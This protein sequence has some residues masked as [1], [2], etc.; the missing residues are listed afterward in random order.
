MAQV[1]ERPPDPVVEPPRAAIEPVVAA[2]SNYDWLP[3]ALI[4]AIALALRLFDLGSR[5]MHHDESL[6]AMYSWYLYTGRGYSHDPLMHG[7]F[8]FHLT[9]LIFMLFGDSEVTFRLPHVLMGTAAVFLPYFLR[10]ELGRSGAIAA[11]A[12]LAFGPAF[13][14]L[15]R[16]GHNEA[17][18][19]F[20]TLLV[21]VGCFGWLRTR[22]SA[23]LYAAAVG[24]GLMFATKVVVYLFGF[25]L[26][27]F[28]GLAIAVEKL[29][30][31]DIPVLG[32]VRDIG[33]RRFGVVIAIFVGIGMT[34]YTTFFTNIEGLCTA[35]WSPPIGNCESKTGMLQYWQTQQGV[36]RGNQPWFYFFL[37]IP[38]YEIVPFVLAL[39]SPFLARRPRTLFFFFCCWWAVLSVAI[40]SYASEK[41]PWL[42]VHPTMP[43]VM[44]AGLALD[45][46]LSKLRKPWGLK[47]RQWGVAGLTLLAFA[48][49]VAW[50]TTGNSADSLPII[51]QTVTLRRVALALVVVALIAL[52]VR[53][54]IGLTRKQT[55][56]ALGSTGLLLA[57]VYAIHTGWQ[58]TYK[59]GD[60]PV[61]ILVYVQTSP[62]VP[63]ITSEIDRFGNQ[64]GL[65][66]DLP[67]LLD[68]GYSETVGGQQV[69]HES[70]TWP[71][72]WY[73]RDYKAKTYFRRTLPSDFSSGKYPV[74][75][76]MGTNLDPIRD[77][78]GDYAGNKFRLNWWYPEDYKQLTWN[79]IPEALL[80]PVA[81][82][83]LFKYIIFRELINPPLGARDLWFYVRKDLAGGVAQSTDPPTAAPRAPAPASVEAI[84]ISVQDIVVYGQNRL[85]DPKGIT[86][87]E[88]GRLYVV[89][90]TTSTVTIFNRDGSVERS[91][92]S[93]G[94]GNGQFN[95]PW[96]VAVARDG[97]VFVADTWN[98]R[99]QKFD[100]QGRFLAKWGRFEA[101][102]EPGAFY[103]PRDIAITSAGDVLVTDTGNKRIQIFD[104]N[105]NFRRSYGTEGSGPG[106][107]REPVGIAVGRDGR[108]YVADTWNQR[109]QV[110]DGAL[111]PVGQFRVPGWG[112]QGITNKPYIAI[113]PDGQVYATVPDNRS[114]VRLRDGEVAPLTL[115]STPRLQMP[116]GIEV[117]N[118]GR[119]L[120]ADA[121]GAIVISYQVEAPQ[122]SASSSPGPNTEPA[123]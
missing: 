75:L 12:L 36:A 56:G 108:I 52:T 105:G 10:H 87:D 112:A 40:Y 64:L 35:I 68:G 95:E 3:F 69:D 47:G 63:F 53:V 96:G 71:F 41:M 27:S 44:L 78:L 9:A 21:V 70:V 51:A 84:P 25:V 4:T 90:G 5:A 37:L 82:G 58:L 48:A 83:K 29:R 11:S 22:K 2:K 19:T 32:A 66:K 55:L 24:L 109:I 76:A 57:S 99:V 107:F 16:F 100:S 15:S 65:R 67:V 119:L 33:W 54:C 20:Q 115:P 91:W 49:L 102:T 110:F 94:D 123:E 118:D 7:P 77:D 104:Q 38:L 74:I 62:D 80:D 106:Q 6:H 122:P 60:V 59:N 114:V 111:T 45:A 18:L 116:I 13:L 98:H 28:I 8:V 88:A 86:V 30:P 61:E 92:G 117:D 1:A 17:I 93:K 81:R 97:S 79:T 120:V 42:I 34:L 26:V 113:G 39:A 103:G 85:R 31:F 121:Q 43:L 14:Y 72:E 89:D 50:A 73:L 46:P 23:Y 101:G